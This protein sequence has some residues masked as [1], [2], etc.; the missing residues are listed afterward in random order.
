MYFPTRQIFKNV[1]VG[2]SYSALS[3][4]FMSNHNVK[5]VINCS[6]DIPFR[7]VSDG[8]LMVR[9]PHRSKDQVER[10]LP[11]L[12]DAIVAARQRNLVSLI[13][14]ETNQIAPTVCAAAMLRCF[15]E[16]TVSAAV[17][18]IQSLK[19]EAFRP[20][21]RHLDALERYSARRT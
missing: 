14:C 13:H 17:D 11:V 1:Y 8:R 18:H 6:H 10:F 7:Y 9:F 21:V 3:Q 5:V 19:P 20:V 2:S 12:V 4:T 15:P 16:L